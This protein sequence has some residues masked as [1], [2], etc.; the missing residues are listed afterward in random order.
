[1]EE[2]NEQLGNAPEKDDEAREQL[3]R[4]IKELG[5]RK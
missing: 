1:M 2:K 4:G 3:K 5:D